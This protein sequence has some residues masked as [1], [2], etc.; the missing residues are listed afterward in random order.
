MGHKP[1]IR[2]C[3][4]TPERQH[5]ASKPIEDGFD[6][7][8]EALPSASRWHSIYSVKEFRFTDG[9]SEELVLRRGRHPCNDLLSGTRRDQF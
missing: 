6:R 4:G 8:A 5:P 2:T 3:S 7:N 1:G 9:R